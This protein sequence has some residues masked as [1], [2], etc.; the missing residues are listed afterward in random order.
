MPQ[1]RHICK[2]SSS[3]S[4]PAEARS[5]SPSAIDRR[6]PRAATA[7][8]CRQADT[9][10]TLTPLHSSIATS[11]TVSPSRS[12]MRCRFEDFP[13]RL[14][15]AGASS[16]WAYSTR[17]PLATQTRLHMML[18]M[19]CGRRR[20]SKARIDPCSVVSIERHDDGH[21]HAPKPRQA[22]HLRGCAGHV[23]PRHDRTHSGRERI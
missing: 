22:R 1:E 5:H 13:R 8:Y 9:G 14:G 3:W 4:A 23:T 18:H 15:R 21:R 12:R 6:S 11:V 19:H 7:A 10:P 17:I 20:A 2:L 16:K